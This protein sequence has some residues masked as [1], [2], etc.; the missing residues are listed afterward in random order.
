MAKSF[1]QAP[2]AERNR[3][4]GVAELSVMVRVQALT[5]EEREVQCRYRRKS[6]AKRLADEPR[7]DQ[8]EKSKEPDVYDLLRLILTTL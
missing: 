8:K 4:N 5:K 7:C 3:R 2:I 6:C 1:L